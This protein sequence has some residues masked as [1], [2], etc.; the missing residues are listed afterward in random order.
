MEASTFLVGHDAVGF[1]FVLH[2]VDALLPL[3]ESLSFTLIEL[4]FRDSL[5]DALFWLA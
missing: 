3:V 2:A 4:A 1:R 5:A